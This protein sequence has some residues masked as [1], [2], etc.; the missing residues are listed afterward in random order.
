MI[1]QEPKEFYYVALIHHQRLTDLHFESL[2]DLFYRRKAFSGLACGGLDWREAYNSAPLHFKEHNG[3][4]P[5]L[6]PI[7][8][9]I[10]N[11]NLNPINEPQQKKN[12]I[13]TCFFT[14]FWFAVLIK[15][16]LMGFIMEFIMRLIIGLIMGFIMGLRNHFNPLC[17]GQK[18]RGSSMLLALKSSALCTYIHMSTPLGKTRLYPPP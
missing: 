15:F 12:I 14:R 13:K 8:N 2:R 5:I 17:T 10:I 4:N 6:N 3:V 18:S 11:P 7:I 1:Y 16:Y 9:S